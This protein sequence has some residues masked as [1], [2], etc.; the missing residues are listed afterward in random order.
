MKLL[1]N[2]LTGIL[3]ATFVV[4]SVMSLGLA[5]DYQA[6]NDRYG[7]ALALASGSEP[8]GFPDPTA[9]AEPLPTE[10]EWIPI[11]VKTPLP[12]KPQAT[13]P[14]PT[15]P[16]PTAP[17]PTEPEPAAIFD[18]HAP[19]LEDLDLEA[20]REVNPDVIGWI[21]IPGTCISY[22]IVQGEDND[23]YLNHTWDG[24]KSAMGAVFMEATNAADFSNFS[25]ILYGHNLSMGTLF[26]PLHNYKDQSFWEENPFVYIVTDAGS[27]RYRIYA[28]YEVEV[29]GTTYW[30]HVDT[31]LRQ[32]EYVRFGLDRSVLDTGVVPAAGTPVLTL[33]TCTDYTFARRWVVQA[34]LEGP[35]TG[36]LAP[37]LS[38]K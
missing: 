22:P 1:R 33:S 16:S 4:S 21:L 30:R 2:L 37:P 18:L 17:A 3:A 28:A 19:W 8:T 11:P 25:T 7:E 26:R 24:R 15:E 10:P 9:A 31:E 12:Q 35:I 32:Q 13:E 6:G 20:L 5:L 29:T 14:T 27:F 38:L 23:Y 34:V 36:I